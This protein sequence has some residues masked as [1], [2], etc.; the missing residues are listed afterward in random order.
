MFVITKTLGVKAKS[1][2]N[3]YNLE[4]QPFTIL[5]QYGLELTGFH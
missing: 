4:L 5:S 3:A 2:V 1:K